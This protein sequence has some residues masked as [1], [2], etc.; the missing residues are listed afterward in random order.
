ML[1]KYNIKQNWNIIAGYITETDEDWQQTMELIRYWLPKAKDLI[2]VNPIDTFMLL[3]GTPMS[4]MF[5]DFQIS[6]NLVNGYHAFSWTSKLNPTNT[7][8]KRAD[9]FVELCDYLISFD[10]ATY[11]HLKDK[12]SSIKKQLNWYHN[13][14]KKIYSLSQY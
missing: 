5:D 8:D 9:R 6:T 10:H 11:D 13:D 1:I 7:Y 12:I 14:S 2:Y 4:T 3:E